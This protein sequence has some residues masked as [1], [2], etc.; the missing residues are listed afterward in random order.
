MRMYYG[1]CMCPCMVAF[2]GSS[3]HCILFSKSARARALVESSS[4]VFTEKHIPFHS[5]PL[6]LT[7]QA[8]FATAM[9]DY[10]QGPG[11]S[12]FWMIDH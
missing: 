3:A 4:Y 1:M 7:M 2:M 5:I 11:H 12:L 6:N 8:L 10:K 9:D